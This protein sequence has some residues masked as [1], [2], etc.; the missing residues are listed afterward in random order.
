MLSITTLSPAALEMVV[1]GPM[2]RADV[3]SA[4]DQLEAVLDKTET[5]D[6]LVDVRG[7]P[8][9]HLGLIIEELKRL[10]LVIR[11][12]RAIGRVA[13]IADAGWVR[14]AAKIE[15]AVIPGVHYETYERDEAAHARRWLMR[16]TDAPRPS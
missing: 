16:E 15:G 5:L 12:I 13:L 10:P 2:S 3:A 11:M 8:D 9:L 6:L 14:T 1:D 4:F 7:K